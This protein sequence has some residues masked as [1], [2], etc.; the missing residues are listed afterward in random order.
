MK[1]TPTIL[2]TATALS[3]LLLSSPALAIENVSGFRDYS[4]GMTV[5]QV[6]AIT[7]LEPPS[8]Q[9]DGSIVRS[10]IDEI[11]VA[12]ETYD[13]SFRFR[14]GVLD[15]IGLSRMLYDTHK[16]LCGQVYYPEVAGSV[17]SVYGP[18]DGDPE[19]IDFGS[20]MTM[21]THFTAPDTSRIIVTSAFVSAGGSEGRCLLNVS[22]QAPS[23]GGGF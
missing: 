13:L 3:A 21:S 7:D 8:V 2:W 20:M 15:S 5:D 1:F 9:E 10:S 4:F 11:E 16:E 18:S 14:D 22:Y 19:V 23:D 6:E 12:G 17:Q